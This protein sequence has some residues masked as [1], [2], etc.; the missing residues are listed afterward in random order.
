MIDRKKLRVIL[1]R[2]HR[3]EVMA[4]VDDQDLERAGQHVEVA[5]SGAARNSP[6]VASHE[7]ND[8]ALL[9]LVQTRA[10]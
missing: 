3:R 10:R 8:E 5:E 2:D 7:R 1:D 9:L 6:T 4:E